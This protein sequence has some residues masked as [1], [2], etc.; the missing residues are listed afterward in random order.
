MFVFPTLYRKPPYTVD[1]SCIYDGSAEYSGLTYSGA[2]DSRTIHTIAGWIYPDVVNVNQNIFCAGDPASGNDIERV[3]I[4]SSGKFVYE[5]LDYPTP[6]VR[7]R[8]ITTATFS[9]ATWAHFHVTRNGAT[10]TITIDGTVVSA[11]D[12]ATAPAAGAQGYFGTAD[13]HRVGC[14][15]WSVANLFDGKIADLAYLDGVS[16]PA[17]NFISGAGGSPLDLSGLT[18]GSNGIWQRYQN[19][20]SLGQDYSGNGHTYTTVAMDSSNQATDVPT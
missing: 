17:S 6:G 8:Y 3:Y 15:T 4:N 14:Q 20:S 12:T 18:F 1:Y 11:F 7:A 5:I 13:L 9:A 19:S 2:G 16:S 10:V